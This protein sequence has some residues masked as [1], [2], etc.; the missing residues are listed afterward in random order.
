MS[1][2]PSET[3]RTLRIAV[4]ENHEDTLVCLQRYLEGGGHQVTPARTAEEAAHEL[5][6]RPHDVLLC[7]IGL[8][9]RDGWELL[10][11]LES[12]RPPFCIAMS[13]YGLTADLERSRVAGFD[14]HLTKPFLPADL[15]DLLARA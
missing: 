10:S 2:S 4:V 1:S 12:A 14:H 15:D 3:L 5:R 7:D 13:G 8:P 9:D 11:S 6:K